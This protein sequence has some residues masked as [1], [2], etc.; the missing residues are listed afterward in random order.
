MKDNL[1]FIVAA[2]VLIVAIFGSLAYSNDAHANELD[3]QCPQ[4]VVEHYP[5]IKDES[6]IKFKC[7]KRYGVAYDESQKIP[8]YVATELTKDELGGSVKRGNNFYVDPFF[9]SAH[10]S[11]FVGTKWDKGHLAEAELFTTDAQAMSE[12]FCMCNMHPQWYNDNRGIWHAL[13]NYTH[14]LAVQYGVIYIISGTVY[15]KNFPTIGNSVTVPS[16]SWK[17]VYIPSTK[18][19]EAYIIPN[20]EHDHEQFKKFKVTVQQVE[21]TTGLKF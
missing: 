16:A 2:I 18:T 1:K 8:V 12:S 9:N 5:V 21:A 4:F 13:E 11:D 6:H 10:P 7:M 19:T 14:K 17:V 15:G 3:T 20:G